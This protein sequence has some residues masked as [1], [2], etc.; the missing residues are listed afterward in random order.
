MAWAGSGNL[1]QSR[2]NLLPGVRWVDCTTLGASFFSEGCRA[3]LSELQLNSSNAICNALAKSKAICVLN[4]SQKA[5]GRM[6][7]PFSRGSAIGG[8]FAFPLARGSVGRDR[9]GPAVQKC[10]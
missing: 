10:L 7:V 6:P 5:R 9:E 1:A 4:K 3:P 2:P 8:S